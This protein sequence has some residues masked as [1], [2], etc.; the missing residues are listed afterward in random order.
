MLSAGDPV[1]EY[2]DKAVRHVLLRQGVLGI[3][4]K[5]M[6]EWDPTGRQG[7]KTPLPDVVT[8]HAP[9]EDESGVAQVAAG[10]PAAAAA[11]APPAAA[12]PAYTPEAAF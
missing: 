12:A 2:V 1:R 5:I 7:P 3:K 8:V 4:V 10:A 11:P 9:K 6:K